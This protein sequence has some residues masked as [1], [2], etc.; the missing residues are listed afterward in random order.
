V[1]LVTGAGRGIGAQVAL[2]FAREGAHVAINYSRARRGAEETVA[3]IRETGVRATAIRADVRRRSDVVALVDRTER[4]LG[5]IDV[6]VCNAA[7]FV[8]VG[9]L[10]ITDTLWDEVIDT[11]LRSVF[12]CCQEVVRRM[13][14][15]RR[16]VIVNVAS[17]GGISAYPGYKTSVAYAASK[18]GVRMLS[19]RLA[20][21]LAPAIRVNVVAPGIIDSRPEE[22][23]DEGRQS[24]GSRVPAG[25]VGTPA[26]ISAAIRF[27]ASDDARH[28]TGQTLPVD[29][30][31]TM[32]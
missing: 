5:P 15:R 12:L 18:A 23:T 24:L 27:L 17:G 16:G 7:V 4:E 20:H 31:V 28:I 6:L 8:G 29:G 9:I 25:R 32:L 1:V 2:D 3:K 30:G 13:L 10:E 11:N 22:W 19:L 14:P 21:E 26:E